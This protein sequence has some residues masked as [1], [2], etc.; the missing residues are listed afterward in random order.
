MAM[1][2]TFTLPFTLT[3]RYSDTVRGAVIPGTTNLYRWQE[4][5]WVT[6][7]ITVTA[8]LTDGVTAQITQLALYALLGQTNRFYLPILR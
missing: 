1:Q 3:M 6:D 7:G 4:G 2:T 5:Q 8:T